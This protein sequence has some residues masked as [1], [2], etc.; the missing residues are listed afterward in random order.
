MLYFSLPQIW[1]Y[2]K[3]KLIHPPLVPFNWYKPERYS[4]R[5]LK[6]KDIDPVKLI[7]LLK[8]LTFA[9]IQ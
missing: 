8:H 4:D 3:L 1:L 6:D 7:E 9:D 2:K 5:K